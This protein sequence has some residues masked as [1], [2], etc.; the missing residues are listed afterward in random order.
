MATKQQLSSEARHAMLEED[1]KAFLEKGG[2]IEEVE[3]GT[4]GESKPWL[5]GKKPVKHC[6]P[7]RLANNIA[8]G[9]HV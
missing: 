1:I 3:A 6:T 9:V 5:L 7:V 2:K 8:P 4:T